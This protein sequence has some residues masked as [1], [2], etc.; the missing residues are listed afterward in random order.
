MKRSALVLGLVAL[1]SGCGGRSASEPARAR[2]L[3]LGWHETVGRPGARMIVD[4]RKLIVRPQ[5]WEVA[6]SVRNDTSVTFYVGRPHHQGK[7]EF[8][9]LVLPTSGASQADILAA[10]PGV[11]AARVEPPLPRVLRPGEAWSGTFSGRGRLER[12]RYVRV[13]LGRFTTVGTPQ[14]GVPWRFRY[15]TDHV[16]KL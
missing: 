13:E 10:S 1:L 15:I 14:R 11:F 4:V 12:G 3:V 6:A 9:L 2:T 8:G 7:S 5:G 16:V